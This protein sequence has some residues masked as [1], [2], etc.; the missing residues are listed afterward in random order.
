MFQWSDEG[1]LHTCIRRQRLRR[2]RAERLARLLV[3]KEGW[4]GWE[5]PNLLWRWDRSS[6]LLG[7]HAVQSKA[8]GSCGLLCDAVIFV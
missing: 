3:C 8:V 6:H 1:I 2:R 4:S 7:G 5:A